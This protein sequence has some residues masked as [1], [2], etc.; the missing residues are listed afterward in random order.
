[1]KKLLSVLTLALLLTTQA[2]AHNGAISLY[3]D[4]TPSDCDYDLALG[5]NTYLY[6]LYVKGDGPILGNA[7][8]WRILISSPQIIIGTAEW[9]P[10]IVATLGG[11]ETGI[12]VTASSCLGNPAEDYTYIGRFT[13]I[14]VGD[15]D[16]ST[17]KV[18]DDPTDPEKPGV[19]I[20]ICDPDNTKYEVLGGTFIIN[21]TCDPAVEPKSWGAIKSMF[22]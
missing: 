12:S 6:V 17:V 21:G 5:L 1:M 8:Q 16:T 18:V 19:Y 9:R 22:K 13:V 11:L 20:T 7:A 2:F 10:E 4:E 14:N 15:V 3:T